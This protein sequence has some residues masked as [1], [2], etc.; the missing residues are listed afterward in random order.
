MKRILQAGLLTAA[1][2]A[3][4]IFWP[5]VAQAQKFCPEGRTALGAC[6]N[7][8]LAAGARQIAVIFSQPKI[9]RTAYPVLPTGG[10]RRFR[11]PNTLIPDPLRGAPPISGPPIP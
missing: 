9:S 2:I 5:A 3:A 1:A 6:V 4:P 7:P 8:L 10:D 11:Y